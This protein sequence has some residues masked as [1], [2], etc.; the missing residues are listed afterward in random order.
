MREPW[1]AHIEKR[2]NDLKTRK[3]VQSLIV[4]FAHI[5]VGAGGIDLLWNW[6][7]ANEADMR[8]LRI[9]EIVEKSKWKS[10]VHSNMYK[11]LLYWDERQSADEALD[12]ITKIAQSH[13]SFLSDA[14]KGDRT[15]PVTLKCFPLVPAGVVVSENIYSGAYP[16]TDPQR[17]NRFVEQRRVLSNEAFRGLNVGRLLLYHPSGPQP[18][19]F[20][21][22]VPRN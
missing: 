13:W 14:Q 17:F 2:L 22:C 3:S 8:R 6:L 11:A 15:S 4:V 5:A 1:R 18:Q 10:H 12:C 21:G 20:V 19:A 7:M 9:T 16:N